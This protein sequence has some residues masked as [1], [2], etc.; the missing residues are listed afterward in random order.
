MSRELPAALGLVLLLPGC[1]PYIPGSWVDNAPA[2]AAGAIIWNEFDGAGWGG[3]NAPQGEALWG[4][5]QTPQDDFAADWVLPAPVGCSDNTVDLLT[6]TD[7]LVELPGGASAISSATVDLPLTWSPEARLY[8]VTLLEG[9]VG[10]D[11]TSFDLQETALV[12]GSLAVSPFVLVPGEIPYYGPDPGNEDDAQIPEIG[13]D[14][15][16]VTWSGSAADL[17]AVTGILLDGGGNT[18]ERWTCAADGETGEVGIPEDMWDD[19]SIAG[20]DRVI[21]GVIHIVY[22]N[23]AIPDMEAVS[24]GVGSRGKYAVYTINP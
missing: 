20:A 16:T 10:L 13:L 12:S 15:L 17:V 1:W 7:R 23:T 5:F 21:F 24:R 14:Q 3:D 6:W 8:E 19:A 11:A 9:D 4:W 2:R 18:L 22:T